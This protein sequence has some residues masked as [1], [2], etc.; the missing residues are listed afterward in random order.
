MEHFRSYWI[1]FYPFVLVATCNFS[2]NRGNLK[3]ILASVDLD[4]FYLAPMRCVVT[5]LVSFV[6]FKIDKYC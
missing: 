1:I 3:L 2:D 4:L 6:L 5:L